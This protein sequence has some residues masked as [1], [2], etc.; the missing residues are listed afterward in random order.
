LC[1]L[2]LA[3]MSFRICT[4]PQRWKEALSRQLI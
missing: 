3:S 2:N 4:L 1:L